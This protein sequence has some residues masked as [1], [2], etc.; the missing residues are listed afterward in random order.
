MHVRGFLCRLIKRW[1]SQIFAAE[2][3]AARARGWQVSRPP[4]RFGRVYRDPRWDLISLCELC[5]GD[6]GSVAG[7]CQ[8][9]GGHGTIR[10]NLAYIPFRDAP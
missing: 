10:H 2:D 5:G 1:E 6:G 9:C 4:N 3:A 7:P 8:S